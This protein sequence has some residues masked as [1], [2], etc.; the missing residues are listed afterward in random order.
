MDEV[1]EDGSI[2]SWRLDD[3]DEN[4]NVDGDDLQ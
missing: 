3:D 4:S 2:C 1:T